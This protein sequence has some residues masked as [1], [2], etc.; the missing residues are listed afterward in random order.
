LANGIV[1]GYISQ[2]NFFK[3]S[4]LPSKYIQHM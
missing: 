1:S 4:A 2:F 3:H